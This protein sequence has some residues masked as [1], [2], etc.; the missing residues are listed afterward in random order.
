MA[1]DINFYRDG[2]FTNFV[3]NTEQGENVI[4]QML[5]QSGATKVLSIHADSVIRQIKA[6]G[7]SVRK[8]SKAHKTPSLD[9]IFNEL[10][11]YDLA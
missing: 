10:E 5:E 4:R 6:A 1:T 7:Y 2:M 9:E 3:P 8:L 11:E